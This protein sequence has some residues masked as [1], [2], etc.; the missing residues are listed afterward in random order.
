[1]VL[2]KIKSLNNKNFVLMILAVLV[3]ISIVLNVF[4]LLDFFK[5]DDQNLN[6]N[7][8]C[9]LAQCV[10]NVTLSGEEWARENCV[11]TANG[12]ICYAN[13][14]DG[15][16]YQIPLEELNL[17]T[18]IATKCVSYVCKEERPVRSA[19]YTIPINN[20]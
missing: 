3:V 11:I 4:I 2:K 13:L 15:K 14:D 1:M 17:T 20:K 9:S 7:W 8:E 10:K 19:N 18:L 16:Q 12:T 5:S 6:L